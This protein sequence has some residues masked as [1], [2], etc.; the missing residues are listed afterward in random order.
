MN[1]SSGR[2]AVI[3]GSSWR[4]LPAAALRG[5]TK[6]LLAPRAMG[7]PVEARKAGQG[8]ERLAAEP[9]ARTAAGRC[10]VSGA[11][12]LMVLK[13]C[14]MSSPV[15][16]VTAITPCTNTPVLAIQA[17]MAKPSSLGSAE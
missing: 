9:Q 16:T 5:L 2:A 14:V 17:L 3:R 1:K 12:T 15:T 6:T 4:K 13:F 7:F 10:A 11:A 8:H